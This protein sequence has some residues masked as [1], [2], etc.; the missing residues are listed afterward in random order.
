MTKEL[1]DNL[2]THPQ[3][4]PQSSRESAALIGMVAVVVVVVGLT[5]LVGG[6]PS[7]IFL[8]ALL[9]AIPIAIFMVRF[10]VARENL[11][12]IRELTMPLGKTMDE[13]GA[14]RWIGL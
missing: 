5:A 2:A 12:H 14:V 10:A 4:Y 9:T 8:V 1:G 6:S 11:S 7:T 13:S 3:V